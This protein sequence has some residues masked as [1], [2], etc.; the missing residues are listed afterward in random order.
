MHSTKG[1]F[2]EVRG[3]LKEQ[4][5]HQQV[6]QEKNPGSM[7][8]GRHEL[9]MGTRMT[10]EGAMRLHERRTCAMT[11]GSF[12]WL[13]MYTLVSKATSLLSTLQNMPP[14]STTRRTG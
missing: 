8:G 11:F 1:E 5:A 9:T 4:T 3:F 2:E 12:A 10:M 7:Q 13:P 14:L 6:H